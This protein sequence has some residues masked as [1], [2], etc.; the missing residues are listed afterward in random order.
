[1]YGEKIRKVIELHEKGLKDI[2]DALKKYSNYDKS[3]INDHLEIQS[4]LNEELKIYTEALAKISNSLSEI[5]E[6]L[7]TEQFYMNELEETH[8]DDYIKYLLKEYSLVL[9]RMH[10]N[11]EII[12]Q[13]FEKIKKRREKWNDLFDRL[14]S[15]IALYPKLKKN[16]E[17]M[18]ET[19]APIVEG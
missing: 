11:N 10:E 3:I 9:G 7:E 12:E 19:M 5:I 18:W 8:D 14:E 16:M 15:V 1:M 2:S 17:E 13:N 6:D 4:K